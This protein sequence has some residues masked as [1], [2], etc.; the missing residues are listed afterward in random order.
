M[1][2]LKWGVESHPLKSIPNHK[3]N[4]LHGLKKSDIGFKD[5]GE[6]YFSCISPGF[7]KGWKRHKEMTLNLIVPVGLVKFVIFSSKENGEPDQSNNPIE[8]IIG[9]EKYS[10]LTKHRFA[11]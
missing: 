4:V 2:K 1:D 5:F 9:R 3:G 10:R 11:N 6:A 8:Y 7:I